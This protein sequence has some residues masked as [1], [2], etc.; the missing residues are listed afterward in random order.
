[1]KADIKNALIVPQKST[2]EVQDRIYVYVVDKNSVVQ[3]RNITIRQKI[4]NLYVVEKGLSESDTI[5]F[6]GVQSVKE[7]EKIQTVFIPAKQAIASAAN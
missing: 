5:L 6:E 1:L 2:F 3:A 4:T 7:D